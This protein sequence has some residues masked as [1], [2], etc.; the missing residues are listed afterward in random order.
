[1]MKLRWAILFT[2]LTV[3]LTACPGPQPTT[4]TLELSASPN[5][6]PTGGAVVTLSA[7]VTA[8]LE[9]VSSVEFAEKGAAQKLG[10]GTRANDMFTFKTTAPVTANKTYVATARDSA[11]AAIGSAEVSVT[12]G[13]SAAVTLTLAAA[14]NPV[15]TGGAPVVLTATITAGA[16][17]VKSVAFSIKGQTAV[18]NTDTTSPYSFTTT[19]PV[20]AATTFVAT[21]K[22]AAG[23]TLGTPAEV[24]VTVGGALQPV[25]TGA[26]IATTLD[27]IKAAPASGPGATIVVTQNLACTGPTIGEPPC[28]QLKDGQKLL[29]GT[30]DGKSLLN[31]PGIKITITGG[32]ASVIR[33][34]NNTTVEGFEI[35]GTSIYRAIDADLAPQ[36]TG[37][38]TLKNVKV[39]VPT[40]NAPIA[41]K[42]TGELTMTNVEITTTKALFIQDFS[43]ATI[44]GLKI[45][46]D[47]DDTATGAALN[48][49]TDAATSEVIL[50]GLD[51]TT[52]LG[53]GG[54][55]TGS[56]TGVLFQNSADTA[57]GGNLTVTVKNS[58]VTFG[59]SADL[60]SAV[61]FNFNKIA[62]GT[63][64][65]LGAASTG[66]SS[67]STFKDEATYGVGV[68]GGPI[69]IQ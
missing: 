54:T 36:L 28:I 67:N 46:F 61:A 5:P 10:D 60:A 2:A 62:T 6:V 40:T 50:D 57:V 33:M 44:T 35:D 20:T 27:Q 19:T 59:A 41:M 38:L 15:P 23:A 12:V 37:P 13:T 68:T 55:A 21:A 1:M 17:K 63:F 31:T 56:K 43:K 49:Q 47:R 30:A 3:F 16:D 4:A 32:V 14:P 8:G 34:A 45:A 11:G 7:K 42:T 51:M 29:G 69:G 9:S 66:N 65:I 18:L 48:I 39:V 52:D 25:P 24:A 22:D 58:K 64:T 26:T 53:G